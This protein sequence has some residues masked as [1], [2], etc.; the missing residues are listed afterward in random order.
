MKIKCISGRAHGEYVEVPEN[1][2]PSDRIIVPIKTKPSN[3]LSMEDNP[4]PDLVFDTEIYTC[5]VIQTLEGPIWFA[6]PLGTS[7]S[8]LLRRIFQ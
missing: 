2:R 7:D 8:E 6:A 4:E 5:R 3:I 1:V